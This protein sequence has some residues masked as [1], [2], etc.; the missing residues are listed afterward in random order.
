VTEDSQLLAQYVQ[1]RS[2]SAFTEIVSRHIRLV[3][4]AAVRLLGGNQNLAEDVVQIVFS[5]LARK[6]H[7]IPRGAVLSGWLYQ[8]ASFTSLKLLRT[9]RRRSRREREAWDMI[10]SSDENDW[11][12]I[13]PIVDE[14]LQKLAS[15]DRDALLLRFFEN[16][17]FRA[18][19]KT[20]GATQDAAR[21]RVSRAL[22]EV[23]RLLV[24]RGVTVSTAALGAYLS[25]NAL[26]V[27]PSGLIAS[28]AS[29]SVAAA[30]SSA[31]SILNLLNFMTMTKS[32]IALVTIVVAAGIGTPLVLQQQTVN[33]LRQDNATLRATP[34]ITPAAPQADTSNAEPALPSEQFIELL[35]LRNEV[36]MLRRLS[37][38]W[39]QTL[40]TPIATPHAQRPDPQ[41]ATP[42][43]NEHWADVGTRTPE[44]AAQTLL[45]ALKSKNANR[46][47]E[48][49]TWNV[50]GEQDPRLQDIQQHHVKIM[51]RFAS[52][53]KAFSVQPGDTAGKDNLTV[54]VEGTGISGQRMQADVPMT[55]R[56]EEWL[57]AGQ[58]ENLG[59]TPNGVKV[60]VSMPFAGPSAGRDHEPEGDQP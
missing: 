56:G 13:V 50:V 11:I 8:H 14:I 53:L 59:S 2:E 52:G 18:I 21:K 25:T 42:I 40:K 12:R 9:E 31:P 28:T 39:Q 33:Q 7:R 20:I 54:R 15:K 36:A 22:E 10:G 34:V 46:V 45:F 37:N 24:Q 58:I 1:T 48:V 41:L 60:R 5:D 29:A 55:R 49:L 43:A 38:Q 44:A 27:V 17:D 3:Y 32:K 35:R 19:G 4:S 23:R 16:Q 47:S 57:I 51:E 30:V 26:A 6:A